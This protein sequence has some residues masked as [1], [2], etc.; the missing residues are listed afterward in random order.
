M[1]RQLVY[2][3]RNWSSIEAIGRL[4]S[5]EGIDIR[6]VEQV[7]T[8]D[9][10]S[11]IDT[12]EENE[13][14]LT[15]ISQERVWI[16]QC[17][18]ERSIPPKKME[19]IVSGDL[20]RQEQIP[21]GYM[22]VAACDFSKKARDAFRATV[23]SFG[24]QEYYLWGKAEIEDQL[25]LAKNDHLLFAYFGIS[26]QV[27]RRSM[28][29]ELRSR[30]ALKRKLVKELGEVRRRHNKSVLI[31]DPR[32]DDYPHIDEKDIS[33][34]KLQW[35]Y[36]QFFGFHMFEH[37]AFITRRCFAYVDWDKKQ[38]DAL[39]DVNDA[40]PNHPRLL[41]LQKDAGEDWQKRNRYW[42]YWDTIEPK[43]SRAWYMELRFIPFGRIL[44]VD[45]IGDTYHE[46]PHLLVEYREGNDPFEPKVIRLIESSN[47]YDNR[48]IIAEEENRIK[49]F[50]DEIPEVETKQE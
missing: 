31:R 36:W 29:T 18:R 24:V 40:W 46:P 50:P 43:A 42:R 19:R 1:V 5:D 49:F 4:G 28:R 20:S 33:I 37:L 25:F 2:D 27:R 34:D 22:L 30:L 7:I 10:P 12:E 13:L 44:A 15:Q 32:N 14:E 39:L 45:E 48:E 26:L 11:D 16:I 6:A 35:R 47:S 41:D 38:W 23:T 3:F 17:K 9:N 21:Y 8:V